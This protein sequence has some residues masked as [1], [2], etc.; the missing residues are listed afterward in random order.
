MSDYGDDAG[1]AKYVESPSLLTQLTPTA[2]STLTWTLKTQTYASLLF[3][4]SKR[5]AYP[6]LEQPDQFIDEG[7]VGVSG[8]ADAEEEMGDAAGG[9][10]G[11]TT[12]GGVSR[13]SPSTRDPSRNPEDSRPNA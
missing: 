2:A 10:N 6:Y 5:S 3:P 7:D 13:L 1:E 4:N 12:G 9:V 11:A 8:A